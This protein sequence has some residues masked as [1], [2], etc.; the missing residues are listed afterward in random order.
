MHFDAFD[1][2]HEKESF[3]HK[4]DPRVKIPVTVLFIVS[5]ALLPDGAWLA[6][7]LAWL[8]VL[9]VNLI[10][11]LAID[12]TLKRS[13]IAFPFAL[14]AITVLFSVPGKSVAT[15]QLLMWEVIIADTGFLRFI[16]ILMRSWISVQIAILLVV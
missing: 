13:V 7:I 12:F 4:L 16:S 10:A 5:N 15:F 1:R 11:I 14:I 3:L 8:F 2:Y 9:V 6:F